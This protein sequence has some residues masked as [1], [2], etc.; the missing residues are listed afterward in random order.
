MTKQKLE[1]TCFVLIYVYI[2][3]LGALKMIIIEISVGNNVIAHIYLIYPLTSFFP[4]E[5]VMILDQVSFFFF[6]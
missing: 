6:L 5:T 4:V 2:C 1:R 3:T